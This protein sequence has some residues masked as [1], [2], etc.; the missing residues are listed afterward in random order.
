[1]AYE[2]RISD[3]SS[4]VCSSD[5]EGRP[6]LRR[7]PS[8]LLSK[9]VADHATQT[10]TLAEELLHQATVMLRIFEEAQ[11]AGQ[12]V[13]EVNPTCREDERSEER[14]VGIACVRTFR[15]RC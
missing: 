11:Q 1:M 3:W 2:L 7:P 8:V 9:Y 14:S 13:Y 12:F 10:K 15:S 5:L 4:D 6:G